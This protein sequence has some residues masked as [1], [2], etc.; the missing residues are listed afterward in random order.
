MKVGCFADRGMRYAARIALPSL[1]LSLLE[2]LIAGCD[3]EGRHLS[4][5]HMLS[6]TLGMC[7]SPEKGCLR[8][9][10]QYFVGE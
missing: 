2:Y 1:T 3:G 7:E 10:V 6:V 4:M 8:V 9:R 5:L